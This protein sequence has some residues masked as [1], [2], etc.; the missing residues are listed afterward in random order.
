M[1]FTR[2]SAIL[3][4]TSLLTAACQNTGY[5]A[6]DS[7]ALEE[8]AWV[9]KVNLSTSVKSRIVV[10]EV[11]EARQ[12][13]LLRVQVD[14]QNLQSNESSFRTS[15]EWFDIAGFKLDSP[16]DGWMSHIVQPQEKFTITAGA[17]NPDAVSWRLN[18]DTWNR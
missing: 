7:G 8:S 3:L 15:M 6:P 17:V 18:V 1:Q 10:R 2:L 16:N 5:Q 14:L 9:D 11:R 4:L 12:H 13:D